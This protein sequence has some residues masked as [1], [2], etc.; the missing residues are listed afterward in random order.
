MPAGA[1]TAAVRRSA[2]RRT[3]SRMPTDSPAGDDF[4]RYEQEIVRLFY[5]YASSVVWF[6]DPVP[7]EN[8]RL[9]ESLVASLRE[10][11]RLY[12]EG[13][14]RDF[15]WRSPDIPARIERALPE[16]ARRLGDELGSEFAVE[17]AVPDDPPTGGVRPRAEYRSTEAPA[18]PDA[19]AAF[20]A[21]AD[22]SRAERERIAERAA[23]SSGEAKWYARNPATGELFDPT[24]PTLRPP[25]D[26]DD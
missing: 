4:S 20:A 12:D 17:Y 16:L 11:Q 13:L 24:D 25:A 6:P 15:N 22:A 9:S 3:M 14:D 21:R 2:I 23:G 5:D 18:N 7:Y 8:A 10:W 26:P 1:R 19:A